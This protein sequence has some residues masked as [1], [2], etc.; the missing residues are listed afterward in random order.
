MARP[1]R[2]LVEDGIYHV[3]LRGNE[4]RD[5]FY[6]DADRQRF[7]AMLGHSAQAFEIR[8]LLYCLM[9]NHVHLVVQTPQAN[10]SAFM[11]RL[12]TAY[13]VYF[14]RRHRRSG[15]LVQGRFGAKLVQEE[16]YL[17]KLSRYVH[18]NPV[19]VGAMR[20]EPVKARVEFLRSYPWSSYRSYIGRAEPEEFVDYKKVLEGFRGGVSKR[21]R[22]YRGFVESG[23]EDVD[24]A[25]IEEQG[26]SGLCIG[27]EAFRDG[28][29]TLY[30]RLVAGQ[31]RKEDV[32]YR[33][34]RRRLPTDQVLEAVCRGMGVT[35]KELLRS[36]GS[37]WARPVAARMLTRY[38]GLSQREAAQELGVGTGAAV[39]IQLRRIDEAMREGDTLRHQV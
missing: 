31:G 18:L 28:T 29:L 34:S 5:I 30:E 19:F 24:A 1:V 20:R 21:R 27:T 36:H 37:G 10:L 33:A 6:D 23:I 7:L 13:T 12:Q 22:E 17:L 2:L 35:R 3:T 16:G 15:H 38:G 9:T 32:S 25:F 39:S 11:H 4:R 26:A 8:V 14:N